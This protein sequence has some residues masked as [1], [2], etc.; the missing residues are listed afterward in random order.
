MKSLLAAALATTSVVHSQT[1]PTWSVPLPDGSKPLAGYQPV[2]G[3]SYAQA[4]NATP[5][6]G[7]YNHAAMLDWFKGTFFLAWKNSLVDEDAPGQ[8]ILFSAAADGGAAWSPHAEL[9]PNM[10][11]N[12][13]HAS[14]FAAPFV[15]MNA[16]VYAAASPTQFCLYP[17][18]YESVL[19]LRRVSDDGTSF[20]PVFWADTSIPPGFETASALRNVSTVSGMDAAT[21]ADVA[22]LLGGIVPPCAAAD[23]SDGSIK[24]EAC[25]GGCQAWSSISPAL[26]L[27]NERTHYV[28]GG[29]GGDSDILL[30]RSSINKLYASW[31]IG[32]NGGAW[33]APVVTNIPDNNSNIHAGRLSDGR[34]FLLSNPMKSAVIRDPLTIALSENGSG[35]F[36]VVLAAVSCTMLANTPGVNPCAPRY[37]GLWKVRRGKKTSAP[38]DNSCIFIIIAGLLWKIGVP[39]IVKIDG[40][41]PPVSPYPPLPSF[42][43]LF[44]SPFRIPVPATPRVSWWWATRSLWPSPTTRRTCGWPGYPW[45]AWAY[46]DVLRPVSYCGIVCCGALR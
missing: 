32:G 3:A 34:T 42:V 39:V 35:N 24:C 11:T 22:V 37:T 41:Y 12:A 36:S 13:H 15:R 25:A 38:A 4:F 30:Y 16:H 21:Q 8:R 19:L 9:F 26:K 23:G 2:K 10:S 46:D 7:T 6:A 20:G 43:R 44:C 29:G 27:A 18:Q 45:G 31:R 1:L 33:T 28:G 40:L 14:L 17:D 5:A